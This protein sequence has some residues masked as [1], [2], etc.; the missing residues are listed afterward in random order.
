[1]NIIITLLIGAVAGW[2][3]GFFVSKAGGFVG[4]WLLG[5]LGATSP[6]WAQWYGQIVSAVIGAVILLAIWNFVK[7]AF[8]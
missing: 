7:K 4:G 3:S 1:M 6:F 2:L 8:K 5:K